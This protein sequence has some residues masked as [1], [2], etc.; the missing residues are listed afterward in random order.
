MSNRVEINIIMNDADM[1]ELIVLR[2]KRM[3]CRLT[4]KEQNRSIFLNVQIVNKCIGAYA[5]YRGE[6]S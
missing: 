5:Y 4:E 6:E 3:T 2:K 1:Q